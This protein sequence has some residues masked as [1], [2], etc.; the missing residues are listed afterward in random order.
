MTNSVHSSDL[1]IYITETGVVGT[2][3]ILQDGNHYTLTETIRKPIVIEVSDIVL[4][5]NGQRM[6]GISTYHGVTI[7]DQGGITVQN[8]QIYTSRVGIFLQNSTQCIIKDNTI[9]RCQ[10][11]GIRLKDASSFNTIQENTIT[12]SGDEGIYIIDGSN[13]NIIVG[14]IITENESDE[15]DIED[16]DN[17]IIYGNILSGGTGEGIE[18][19]NSN[20]NSIF[21]NTVTNSHSGIQI[22]E[23]CSYNEIFKNTLSNND[24]GIHV[25]TSDENEIHENELAYNHL[26][27]LDVDTSMNNKIYRN[28]IHNNPKGLDI[29]QGQ[30]NIIYY[31]NFIENVK[32]ADYDSVINQWTHEELGGNYWDDYE[33]PDAN[34]D[35]FGDE[36]KV[37]KSWQLADKVMIDEENLD[38]LPLMQGQIINTGRENSEITCTAPIETGLEGDTVQI[39]GELK[40]EY[41]YPV[42]NEDTEITLSII[43]PSGSQENVQIQVIEGTY[44]YDYLA[45][46][47]GQYKFS[48][49]WEGNILYE[50]DTSEDVEFNVEAEIITPPEPEPLS[51]TV[52]ITVQ[53]T[54]GTYETEKKY[55]IKINLK[56]K[57]TDKEIPHE[58]VILII[59]NPEGFETINELVTDTE[60]NI[61]Y[62]MTWDKP[63]KW[64]YTVRW[65][66]SEEH[67]PT[68]KSIE[69]TIE[70]KPEEEDET[71]ERKGPNLALVLLPIIA[72]AA[73]GY[74]YFIYMRKEK[75]TVLLTIGTSEE[76]EINITKQD[77][78]VESKTTDTL[79][80]YE[81]SKSEN[82]P[83][84][85]TVSIKK[86]VET[87][88]PIEITITNEENRILFIKSFTEQDYAFQLDTV[89]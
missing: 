70:E 77:E 45:E 49:S 19:S 16:C 72:I 30:G 73:G 50:G 81:F 88:N 63:G 67:L 11:D 51:S 85:I 78:T 29:D 8:L 33:G 68:E 53:P 25:V 35:G 4:D 54:E 32:H 61:N 17:Q 79:S 82:E 62:D 10:A 22:K 9:E 75:E 87:S 74:Y 23:L 14:N 2:E 38:T 47:P 6:E 3:S 57:D 84:L 13:S 83:W 28:D 65:E 20:N 27:G 5:G 36:P 56:E 1:F 37:L 58:T 76:I 26:S 21:L 59:E 80:T 71:E 15:I 69:K 48:A 44:A 89:L 42:Q 12:L 43:E 24:W 7:I 39:M 41:D 86:V 18:A 34:G 52:T 40:R 31:N 64:K 46:T 55:S 60:G 66:G